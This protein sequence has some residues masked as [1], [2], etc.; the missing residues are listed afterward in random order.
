MNGAGRLWSGIRASSSAIQLVGAPLTVHPID[1]I[2]AANPSPH[3]IP[4]WNPAGD[5][6]AGVPPGANDGRAGRAAYEYLVAAAHAALAGSCDAITTA[7]LSKAALHLA[8]VDFPGHTEI[9]A[10][11]CNVRDFAMMLY[12]PGDCQTG[13]LRLS[14]HG[15][16]VAHVTLHTSIQSVPGLLTESA[17]LEKIC[18]VDQFMRRVGVNIPRI[19]VC[20]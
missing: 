12:L 8:G 5:A 9:L 4:C 20:A 3:R 14:G 7:P 10:S 13:S 11:V 16:G 1:N 2:D 18:L 6:A 19:G 15:L 17:V